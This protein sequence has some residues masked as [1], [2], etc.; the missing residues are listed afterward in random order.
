MSRTPQVLYVDDDPQELAVRQELLDE[1]GDFTVDIAAS[2]EEALERLENGENIDLILSDLDMGETDG[3]EFL[4]R[5][6]DAYPDLP[7]I[8]FTGTD[9]PQA[10]DA[11]MNNGATDFIPKSTASLSYRLLS[12]RIEN[13]LD[14][15]SQNDDDNATTDGGNLAASIQDEIGAISSEEPSD[16]EV[17]VDSQSCPV[18]GC[19]FEATSRQALINHFSKLASGRG[20]EAS[21]HR[22]LQSVVFGNGGRT[23]G[24][25]KEPNA[26]VDTEASPRTQAA[27]SGSRAKNRSIA[28]NSGLYEKARQ[29]GIK[30]RA[31]MSEDELR[32]AINSAQQN[33]ATNGVSA[34]VGE[35][36]SH[37]VES[38]KDRGVAS[39][40][41]DDLH[42]IADLVARKL[43]R[44]QP[45]QA[46]QTGGTQHD[47]HSE[48]QRA[49]DTSHKL[50]DPSFSMNEPTWGNETPD[51][52]LSLSLDLETA[53]EDPDPVKEQ[54]S[55]RQSPDP[56]REAITVEPGQ[57]ALLTSE[58]HGTRR[59]EACDRLLENPGFL[60]GSNVLLIRYRGM[61]VDRLERIAINARQLTIISIGHQQRV[62]ASVEDSVVSK[63]I[64]KPDELRRLG[65]VVTRAINDWEHEAGDIRVCFDSLN[66]LLRYADVQ[67]AFRFLHLLLSKLEMADARVHVHLDPSSESN[68]DVNMI[69]ALFDRVVDVHSDHFQAIEN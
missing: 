35:P 16:E 61:D 17:D 18:P 41:E 31:Q 56:D 19:E 46:E 42:T 22:G 39:L 29:L 21:L 2:P 37:D 50:T 44:N 60:D 7:F 15:V 69:E 34:P 52:D 26:T 5:V 45:Q 1:H 14:V 30:G 24:N 38:S 55:Q 51:S 27:D 32:A 63:R 40:N 8:L 36:Q 67:H 11:A 54:P 64:D 23:D 12:K 53:S 4:Q 58:T 3:I 43:D 9:T 28:T 47:A 20:L 13:A 66:V 48:S 10:V 62:P 33:G 68:Q 59:I 6:R 49:A 57:S 65:I 25:R